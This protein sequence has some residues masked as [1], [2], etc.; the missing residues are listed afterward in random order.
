MFCSEMRGFTSS[1]SLGCVQ[2]A[3]PSDFVPTRRARRLGTVIVAV[4]VALALAVAGYVVLHRTQ[5]YLIG[6]GCKARVSS[7]SV[8]LD[9]D[10]A[11][12]AGTIAGVAYRQHVPEKAVT[13]AYATAMQESH[14]H[15]VNYGD[16]D[17]VGVFQQRPSEGWGTA[18]QLK[19]P[20]YAATKFFEALVQIPGYQ[21]MPVYTAAQEVQHSAD[22]AAYQQYQQFAELLSRAFTG[23]ASGGVWCWYA[24]AP[25]VTANLP[26]AQQQL[27]R[28]F[29]QLDA[30]NPQAD[31]G[32]QVAR[33]MSVRAATTGVGWS[34]AAWSVAHAEDY[35]IRA[36]RYAGYE[37]QAAS[38]TSGW[39]RVSGAGP[40]ADRVELS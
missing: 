30:S 19:D 29:G 5:P 40:P 14:L 37:W 11:S 23:Q 26:L 12:I 18:Q 9:P 10:Q 21:R 35:G 25:K 22:G 27:T 7:Q 8:S 33:T 20:V 2:V 32:S 38:G 15:N 31:P 39:Q 4:P 16:R 6:P 24:P 34:M 13:V 28:T 1:Q 17:S 3:V 36:V